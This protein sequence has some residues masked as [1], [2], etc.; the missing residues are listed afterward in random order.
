MLTFASNVNIN[1]SGLH[2]LTYALILHPIAGGV[3]LLALLMGLLGVW[4]ASRIATIFMAVFSFIASV[5]CLVVFVIDM[6]LWNLV[7]TRIR[8]AGHDAMLVSLHSL[9]TRD[10]FGAV[11]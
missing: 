11:S 6:V 7:R 9:Q 3:A 4:A 2:N 10:R 1:P 5:I 8:D